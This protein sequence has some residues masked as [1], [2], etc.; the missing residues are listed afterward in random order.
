MDGFNVAQRR[1]EAVTEL[2]W[3]EAQRRNL[4]ERMARWCIQA[5]KAELVKGGSA[6]RAIRVA[7]EYAARLSGEAA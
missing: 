5:A 2:A 1:L 4:D 7:A 3:Q 6:W